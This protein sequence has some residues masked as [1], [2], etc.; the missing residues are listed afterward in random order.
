MDVV[1][2]WYPL[3]CFDVK[4]RVTA[5]FHHRPSLPWDASAVTATGRVTDQ[6]KQR[7]AADERY[8]AASL[9]VPPPKEKTV[10]VEQNWREAAG[11][12][13]AEAESIEGLLARVRFRLF[14]AF[15]K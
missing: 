15:L 3:L 2:T 9:K 6:H 13:D 14:L 1:L 4:G 5:T 11:G 7:L 8:F 10:R 12:H